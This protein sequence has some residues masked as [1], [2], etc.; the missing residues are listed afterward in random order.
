LRFQTFVGAMTSPT[1]TGQAAA[2][3]FIRSPCILPPTLM[4]PRTVYRP[5]ETET[6]HQWRGTRYAMRLAV[7][8]APCLT[9][10]WSS[11][12]PPPTSLLTRLSLA[13][14][15]STLFYGD[16]VKYVMVALSLEA[17]WVGW[18]AVWWVGWLAV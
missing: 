18:R 13:A 16:L 10:T 8:T 7:G 5:N 14:G 11:T 15:T 1:S 2:S 4:T 3:T 6:M 12:P 17:E 9:V